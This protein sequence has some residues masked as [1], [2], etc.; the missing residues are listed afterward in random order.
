MAREFAHGEYASALQK[1]DRLT[2]AEHAKVVQDIARFTALSPKYIEQ[3]NLRVSPFRWFKELKRDQRLTVGRLDSR[4]TG[5]DVDAAGERPEYDS[6]E[7]S[8]EGAY[9]ATFH[10]YVHRDLKWNSGDMYYTVTANVRPWDQTGDTRGSRSIA[11]GHD[12]ADLSKGSG[13]MRLLRRGNAL[14]W[15]RAHLRSHESRAGAAQERQLRLLRIRPHGLHRPQGERQAPPR[16]HR[17]YQRQLSEVITASYI[18]RKFT[19]IRALV[20]IGFPSRNAGRNRH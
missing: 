1:G 6:S 12:A 7:A 19:S 5:I 18:S 17:L 15:N 20:G 16:H 10:D 4:F 11:R 9:V 8:Y 14:Q 3:T 2:P 13:R